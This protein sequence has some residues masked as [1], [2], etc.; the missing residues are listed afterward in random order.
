MRIRIVYITL[1]LILVGLAAAEENRVAPDW[2]LQTASGEPVTLSEAVA[3][4]PVLL[5]FWAT[6]CPYCKAL[7][8]HIQSICLEY[9]N[10]VQVLAVHFRDDKGD[11]VGFMHEAGYDFTLL[12]D[13][14]EVAELNGIQ[15]TPGVLI[16]DRDRRVRFDLYDLPPPDL[17]ASASAGGHASKAALLAPYWA[18]EIRRSLDEVLAD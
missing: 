1:G 15:A 6:W 5:V 18:A 3:E 2:T 13:G 11:P 7:L 10:A 16:L 9:G 17:P 4:R 14:D 8:P 12:E